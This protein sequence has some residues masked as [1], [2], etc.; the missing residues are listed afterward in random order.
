MP[1]ALSDTLTALRHTGDP[2]ADDLVTTLFASGDRTAWTTLQQGVRRNANLNE[3]HLQALGL[4][5][6]LIAYLLEQSVLP[7]W[8][9]PAEM[10]RGSRFFQRHASDILYLLGVLSLPYCY[11]A[12]D[13]ARVLAFSGRIVED[14]RKR[15]AETASYVIEVCTPGA[16]GPEGTA[17]ASTLRVRLIHAAIRHGLLRSGRWDMAWGLPV[18]QEDMAGTNLA[19][20]YIPVRGMR[21]MGIHVP[22]DDERALLHVWRVAGS[23]MGVDPGIN[24]RH[25]AAAE[26][27]DRAIAARQFRDSE[28]GR[29]LTAALLH[30]LQWRF[31]ENFNGN[32][33]DGFI[34]ELMRHLLGDGIA[35]ML[36]VPPK[37]GGFAALALAG[38]LGMNALQNVVPLPLRA[39]LNTEAL[40]R[41]GEE[42]RDS[43]G[44]YVM[45]G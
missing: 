40:A 21:K 1:A 8:A 23:L 38:V 12:A 10:A 9:D 41:V 4:P 11:A 19:F 36:G 16:F 14:T 45:P 15:L 5:E 37:T 25:P 20:S 28:T 24:P 29:A 34:A 22:K 13:G 7:E 3:A 30:H 2:L 33:P 31:D 18:N 32:L 26:E 42:L 27:L 44:D 39:K 43:G 17:I 35:D 6:P